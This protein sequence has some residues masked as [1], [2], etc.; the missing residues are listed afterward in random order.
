MPFPLDGSTAIATAKINIRM[1]PRT[2][3]GIARVAVLKNN[4]ARSRNPPVR[5]PAITPSG[6]PMSRE[7]I[8]PLRANGIELLKP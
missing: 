7:S 5:K 4:R 8:K 6:G 3:C 2:N 1:M